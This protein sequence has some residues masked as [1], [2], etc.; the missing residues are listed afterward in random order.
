MYIVKNT[1]KGS[2]YTV[3]MDLEIC[4]CPAGQ[5]GAPCKH[6]CAV[7]QEFNLTSSLVHPLLQSHNSSMKKILFEVAHGHQNVPKDWFADLSDFSSD[8]KCQDACMNSS[9]TVSTNIEAAMSTVEAESDDVPF[10]VDNSKIGFSEELLSSLENSLD[11]IFLKY[12]QNLREK[13][14]VFADAMKAFVSQNEKFSNSETG[15][16]SS[17]HTFGKTSGTL[18][19]RFS[20][21]RSG[22]AIPVQPAS[23][24]RRTTYLGG[25]RA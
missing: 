8:E 4:S 24:A 17:L 12:K 20:K 1:S 2:E 22:S 7:V 13:P 25:K 16:L 15:L 21:I 19:L 14:E 6:L 11:S 10:N 9:A 3:V 23:K 5:S 18:P